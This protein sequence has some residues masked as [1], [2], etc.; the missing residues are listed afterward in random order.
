[1]VYM[2]ASCFLSDGFLIKRWFKLS[3]TKIKLLGFLCLSCVLGVTLSQA[4]ANP[5]RQSGAINSVIDP[6]DTETNAMEL[7]CK[8]AKRAAESACSKGHAMGTAGAA[9]APAL[10]QLAAQK[11]GDTSKAVCK[12][13]DISKLT[14]GANAAVGAY[15]LKKLKSCISICEDVENVCDANPQCEN[16]KIPNCTGSIDDRLVSF[17]SSECDEP[18][19]AIATCEELKSVATAALAQAGILGLAGLM[20]TKACEDMRDDPEVEPPPPP[21]GA[22]G[23]SDGNSPLSVGVGTLGTGQGPGQL[24]AGKTT[25]GAASAGSAP[26]EDPLPDGDDKKEF[27]PKPLSLSGGSGSSP[28]GAAAGAAGD[29]SGDLASEEDKETGEDKE[30]ADA[31]YNG[32]PGEGFLAGGSTRAGGGRSNYGGG[33]RGFGG[34]EKKKDGKDGLKAKNTNGRAKRGLSQA[35]SR[36]RSI[37]EIMSELIQSYCREGESMCE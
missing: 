11:E 28:G 33:R 36:H 27:S 15:C 25:P 21:P 32:V 37:F 8:K 20:M 13:G 1:M 24:S 31:L 3:L 18:E 19:E 12:Q 17:P 9:L 35:K 2:R 14:G 10:G 4:E 22:L 30:G 26:P 34:P 23:A 29:S 6:P 5:A 16:Q 7:K